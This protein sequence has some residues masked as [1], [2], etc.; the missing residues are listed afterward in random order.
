MD[1]SDHT[2]DSFLNCLLRELDDHQLSEEG[3]VVLL[4]ELEPPSE[5]VKN[6]RKQ[7]ADLS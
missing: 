2:D 1:F 3:G 4:D 7:I 6:M 5:R